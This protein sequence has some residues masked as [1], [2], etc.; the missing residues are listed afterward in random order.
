[1]V[2][3]DVE[4]IIASVAYGPDARTRLRSDTDAAL[5]GAW[6]P[7]GIA[8]AIAE[9]HLQKLA[10]LVRLEWPDAEVAAPRLWCRA[11]PA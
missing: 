7:V 2:V 5:F 9:A 4:G 6:C 11:R 10:A 1:M 3:R 8:P